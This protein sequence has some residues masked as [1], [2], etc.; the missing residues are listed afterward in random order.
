MNRRINAMILLPLIAILPLLF[1]ASFVPSQTS[2]GPSFDSGLLRRAALS[3]DQKE[4]A[5]SGCSPGI[6]S[7]NAPHDADKILCEFFGE[8]FSESKR[9]ETDR[10]SK[11]QLD[12]IIVTIPD[13]LD[14]RLP[15]LFDRN[16]GSIQRAAESQGLVLDR[17]DL[18]WIEEIRR[19]GAGK[20][21]DT[22]LSE[23]DEERMRATHDFRSS[24]GFLLF[25][26]PAIGKSPD[27]KPRAVLLFLVGETPT[28][29]IHKTAML[30][31]L[32]QIDSLCGS[33]DDSRRGL[34]PT[35]V[36][37]P[38]QS[39]CLE[40]KILGPSFSGS[41]ESL[42]FTLHSWLESRPEQ[43]MTPHFR[44][45][46]G[47]ATAIPYLEST[48]IGKSYFQFP[49]V[50]RSTFASTV[51]RDEILVKDLFEY[52]ETQRTPVAPFRVAFLTEANTAYGSS[53]RNAV[54]EHE[55]T[56]GAQVTALPFPLHISRLRSESEKARKDRQQAF[57][58]DTPK[59]NTSRFLP[60]PTEDDSG[61][62][63]DSVPSVSQLDISSSELILS[64]LLA[65][66]S[67]EQFHY[68]G[69]AATDVRDVIFLAR[70]I[71]E[72]SPSTVIFS[73][74]ADLLYA[75]PEA[76][77]NMRGMLVITPYPLFTLNQLWMSADPKIGTRNQFP[78]QSSEGV[79][80]AMLA[81]LNST[82]FLEYSSPFEPRDRARKPPLW[83]MTVGR[84]GFWPVSI[85]KLNDE[86]NYTLKQIAPT[87]RSVGQPTNRGIVPQ[88]AY[89]VL[90]LWS[91]IC[92]VP[93]GAFLVRREGGLQFRFANVLF[94]PFRSKSRFRRLLTLNDPGANTYY[95]LGGTAT[96]SVYT[97]AIAAFSISV[98][99]PL[100]WKYLVAL[101]AM[102]SILALGWAACISLAA[103]ILSEA[104]KPDVESIRRRKLGL[105]I[106]M[107]VG[108][109]FYWAFTFVLA[110]R[111]IAT[112]V[113]PTDFEN[114]F[115]TGFRAINLL[116]GVSPLVPLLFLSLAV[117]FW[118][119]CSI[120]RLRMLEEL[121]QGGSISPQDLTGTKNQ[122]SPN[123]FFFYSNMRSFR[124]LRS[125]EVRIYEH[126]TSPI[127]RFPR[128]SRIAVWIC[129]GL[130]LAWGT[131][132][133][134]YR[135][136]HSFESWIFYALVGIVFLLVYT[137]VLSNVLRLFFLWRSVRE[138]LN[139]LGQLPMLDAFSLF[140]REH[141]N[142]PRMAL[143]TAPSP[144]TVTGFSLKQARDLL[145]TVQ[146]FPSPQDKKIARIILEGKKTL[147][148]AEGCY[149]RAL[150]AEA[151]RL[152]QESVEGQVSALQELNSFSRRVESVLENYWREPVEIS[153]KA[154]K[155]GRLENVI[156]SWFTPDRKDTETIQAA[157]ASVASQ[158]EGFLVSRTVHLL[159]YIF[160]QLTNLTA[161]T[162]ICLFLMLSAIVSYPFQPGSLFAYFVWF[163][164]AAFMAVTV[165]MVLQM[166]RD[167]VI[168]Y[169]NGNKPG[170]IR[171]S[172]EFIGRIILLAVVPI[173]GLL[174]VQYPETI[175]QLVR[176]LAP[177][178][179]GHP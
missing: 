90:M 26:D 120:R 50:S 9:D 92:L 99:N 18:P 152:Q 132:L 163:A 127:L 84:D 6:G 125:L 78:D 67:E 14:S 32:K 69:I 2:P 8:A 122:G 58:Q 177:S 101:V 20:D 118:A 94:R 108:T 28:A 95:L 30:S 49:Q 48:S 131:Y 15:Y 156:W 7:Q 117:V 82:D 19:R 130:A 144:L 107:L 168:S 158:A 41:A 171:W 133:F 111:W 91:L 45:R 29:G 102:V 150:D 57:Q 141:R 139:R 1:P 85:R 98:M 153:D 146:K 170:E 46:S 87:P 60:L 68:A 74:N 109:G 129:L 165:C 96:L 16:L 10:R 21:K 35:G 105:A 100:S 42:D 4:S 97:I 81:M 62:A 73:L 38:N 164:I 169:V 159:A 40:I 25:R 173:L 115:L 11:Y 106:A 12:F 93:A 27:D 61:E 23:A 80:N 103:S 116:N 83:I 162:L 63:S 172:A 136:V 5:L 135:L 145:S 149:E 53:V 104:R 126:L 79:Y 44:I 124:G 160:P 179:A 59:I 110:L 72:H 31:A 64:N 178:G 77:P 33:G 167:A 137:F 70:E 55:S 75:H 114:G 138:L 142:M 39:V 88:Y 134:A 140:N 54:T 148:H 166:N 13:P 17:F 66:I 176:W 147:E 89:S 71:R 76:N 37:H 119:F 51:V 161:Y 175:G 174:G 86:S 151:A 34:L 154:R 36:P 43:L 22:P 47:T 157:R 128:D 123:S 3:S 65:T 143:A 52:L 113:R 56:T 24:P 121:P 155:Q 112:R